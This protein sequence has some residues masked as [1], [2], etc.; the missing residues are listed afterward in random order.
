[1]A[2]TVHEFGKVLEILPDL[3]I[4]V[5][6]QE[7]YSTYKILLE[8]YESGKKLK[9]AGTL[10]K[11]SC[12]LPY[13]SVRLFKQTVIVESA[14]RTGQP[15][16]QLIHI[17]YLSSQFFGNGISFGLEVL[18]KSREPEAAIK[19][20]DTVSKSLSAGVHAYPECS[21]HAH[22]RTCSNAI[23][24]YVDCLLFR[25][26]CNLYIHFDIFYLDLSPYFVEKIPNVL[27]AAIPL[28]LEPYSI[29]REVMCVSLSRN[30]SFTDLLE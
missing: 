4:S 25:F 13:T 6:N 9:L 28:E 17:T 3:R 20:E 1:M 5:L 22:Y 7:G 26:P 19:N 10:L 2:K 23:Y 29:R 8:A 14:P 16:R 21:V 11:S 15:K 12:M 18:A 30:M 24:V 27:A